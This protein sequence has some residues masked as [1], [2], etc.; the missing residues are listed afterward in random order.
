MSKYQNRWSKAQ[1]L[2]ALDLMKKVGSAE[3]SRRFG[4]S[5]TSLYKWLD[6]YEKAGDFGLQSKSG[7]SKTKELL[8]LE[9]ENATLK[10]LVAEKELCIR[11]Q[12]EMLKKSK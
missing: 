1:K 9:R 11:I 12:K 10:T 2:E 3:T 6:Q 8:R 4:V 5:T 7:K